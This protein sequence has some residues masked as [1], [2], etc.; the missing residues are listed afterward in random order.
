MGRLCCVFVILPLASIRALAGMGPVLPA[1]CGSGKAHYGQKS[2]SS[3]LGRLNLIFHPVDPDYSRSIDMNFVS[4]G[5]ARLAA[6]ADSPSLDL[7]TLSLLS[8][9]HHQVTAAIRRFRQP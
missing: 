8:R 7:A 6:G 5:T 4:H 1:L 2:T 9:G 3:N